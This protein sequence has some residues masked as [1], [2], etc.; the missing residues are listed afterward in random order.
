M[1]SRFSKPEIE[2]HTVSPEAYGYYMRKSRVIFV[3]K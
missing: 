3:H 1:S 2:A